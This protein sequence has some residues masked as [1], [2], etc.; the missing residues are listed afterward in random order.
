MEQKFTQ[1]NKI[2]YKIIQKMFDMLMCNRVLILHKII[3]KM[4]H[5]ILCAT[6]KF[7]VCCNLISQCTV[8]IS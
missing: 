3:R 1:M 5:K 8:P 6:Q 7:C 2:E 4:F